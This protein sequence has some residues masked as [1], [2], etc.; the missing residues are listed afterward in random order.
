MSSMIARNEVSKTS[1]YYISKERHLELKH[2]CFQYH[3]WKKAY[4]YIELGCLPS[5]SVF[6]A[7]VVQTSDI[8]DKTAKLALLS[9]WYSRK[10]KLVEDCA[11][12]AAPDIYEYLLKGVT[13][14]S[15]SYTYLRTCLGM[16]CCKVY[17]YERYRAFFKLLSDRKD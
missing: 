11:R 12:E 2:F 15:I 10:I 16:P 3:D 7:G 13:D 14:P 4:E 1:Q 9:A 17:Y 8:S 5:G 6:N